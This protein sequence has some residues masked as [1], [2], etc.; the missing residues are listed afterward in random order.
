MTRLTRQ[1]AK[2]IFPELYG[3]MQPKKVRITNG[4]IEQ[5]FLELADEDGL[6]NEND[7]KRLEHLKLLPKN[8]TETP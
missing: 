4:G 3:K 5:A 1:E 7:K 6:L 2:Q 8:R